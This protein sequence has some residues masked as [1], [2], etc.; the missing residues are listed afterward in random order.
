MYS[1][2]L[3]DI[4]RKELICTQLQQNGSERADLVVGSVLLSILATNVIVPEGQL[5]KS[6][7]VKLSVL[8]VQRLCKVSV[9]A[10]GQ[11]LNITAQ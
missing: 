1:G 3:A 6:N 7:T 8:I 2:R 11:V 9:M 5:F 4:G 10:D